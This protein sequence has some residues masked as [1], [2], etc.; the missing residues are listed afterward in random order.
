MRFMI[1]EVLLGVGLYGSKN[2][3]TVI[4]FAQNVSVPKD[5]LFE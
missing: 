2:V 5:R 4:L 3:Q 1:Y